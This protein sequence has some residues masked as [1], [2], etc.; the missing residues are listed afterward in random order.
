MRADVPM[1]FNTRLMNLSF[2][3][4]NATTCNQMDPERRA[5]QALTLGNTVFPRELPQK[6]VFPATLSRNNGKTWEEL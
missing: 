4:R 2:F 3:L 6:D 1:C 5:G